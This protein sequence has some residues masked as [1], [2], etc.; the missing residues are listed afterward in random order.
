[1][2]PQPSHPIDPQAWEEL[3]AIGGSDADAMIDEL[4]ALYVEDADAFVRAIQAGRA[5]LDCQALRTAAHGLRSPSATLG[6]LQ[7]A[8]CCR[9]LEAACQI[10]E[11]DAL[12]P[13]VDALL[14]EVERVLAVLRPI[15]KD[16]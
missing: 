9:Q 6:A 12:L 13:L 15:H 14:L 3:R 11:P 5:S 16:S 2:T 8:E 4:A 1:M 7:L 10:G